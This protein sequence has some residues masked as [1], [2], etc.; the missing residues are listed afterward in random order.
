MP[1]PGQKR[2]NCGHAMASFDGHASVL[3][4]V[5]RGRVRNPAFLTRTHL[6]VSFA[7]CLPLSSVL[8]YLHLPPHSRKKSG[9]QSIWTIPPQRKIAPLWTLLVIGVVGESSTA[10]S[11]PLPPEK[12]AKKENPRTKS[13]KSASS[14]SDD[15]ISAHGTDLF[16]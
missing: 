1:S 13:K 8:K 12:K 4:V 3:V 7:V 14:A 9:R 6:T 16:L 5:K 10:Q 11:P 2:G 15:R